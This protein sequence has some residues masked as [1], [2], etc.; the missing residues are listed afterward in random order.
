MKR[1][2]P[3][4]IMKHAVVV[5]VFCGIVHYTVFKLI[6]FTYNNCLDLK[7]VYV[8]ILDYRLRKYYILKLLISYS[9]ISFHYI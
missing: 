6:Q 8:L 4:T 7:I 9:S 3:T 2:V 5:C 1:D